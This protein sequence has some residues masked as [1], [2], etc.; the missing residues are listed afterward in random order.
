MRVTILRLSCRMTSRISSL[1][2]EELLALRQSSTLMRDRSHQQKDRG[3]KSIEPILCR[4]VIHA[5]T[6]SRNY[7]HF[8]RDQSAIM[9]A[10]RCTALLEVEFRKSD[11]AIVKGH[12]TAFFVTEKHLLTAGHNIAADGPGTV[13]ISLRIAYPGV[14]VYVADSS[15]IRT[16]DCVLLKTLYGKGDKKN[17]SKDIAILRCEGLNGGPYLPLSSDH[18][19]SNT[20]VDIV[21][22][23]SV[24]HHNCIARLQKDL[25]DSEASE[26]SS[27]VLLPTDTL[28][29]TRG[30][31]EKTDA[32]SGLISYKVSTCSGMSGSCLLYEG[33]VYGNILQ[34]INSDIRHSSWTLPGFF[35]GEYRDILH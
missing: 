31:V 9:K 15:A 19:P 23:P 13:R 22:Y 30:T 14:K 6:V 35:G 8:H 29:V 25:K 17:N 28:V 33:K 32:D 26:A 4:L 34:V 3:P 11:G 21:G 1:K 20:V 16:L 27:K 12:G 7:P 24:G 18:L 5:D 10:A 2:M